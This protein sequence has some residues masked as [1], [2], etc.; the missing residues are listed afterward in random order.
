MA[1]SNGLHGNQEV[2]NLFKFRYVDDV[3]R[4]SFMFWVVGHE[5]HIFAKYL[6]K[7]LTFHLPS[8]KIAIFTMLRTLW[9]KVM[10]SSQYAMRKQLLFWSQNEFDHKSFRYNWVFQKTKSVVSNS[11]CLR[12]I[13][14]LF[15][16]F[17]LN[18]QSDQILTVTHK[19]PRT[20]VDPDF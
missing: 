5:L 17:L 19:K 15:P 18:G 1:L 14:F 11:L 3:Y 9:Q 12:D 10:V 20:R 2:Q 8:E 16:L 13:S 4:I 6:F 7:S